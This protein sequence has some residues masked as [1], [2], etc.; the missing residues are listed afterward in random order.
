MSVIQLTVSCPCKNG[1]SILCYSGTLFSVSL[2][3]TDVDRQSDCCQ[4]LTVPTHHQ[5]QHNRYQLQFLFCDNTY[6]SSSLY[7]MS[8][9]D[10]N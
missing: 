1:F 7:K 6:R 10:F 4:L 9:Q 5:K 2:F 8:Q 3:A